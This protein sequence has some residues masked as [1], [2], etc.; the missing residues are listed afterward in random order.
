[1][2]KYRIWVTYAMQTKHIIEAKNRK[3]AIEKALDENAATRDPGE[4]VD[5]S[6]E[7]HPKDIEVVHEKL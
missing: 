6:P 1:M 3:E 5:G 4:M 2:K 7:V